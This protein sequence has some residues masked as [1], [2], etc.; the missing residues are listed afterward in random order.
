MTRSCPSPTPAV[1]QTYPLLPS[2]ALSCDLLACVHHP[3]HVY[4]HIVSSSAVL[5]SWICLLR[6]VSTPSTT[7]LFTCNSQ[8]APGLGYRKLQLSVRLR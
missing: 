1:R 5:G 4:A 6:S 3:R 7:L 2:V 8:G